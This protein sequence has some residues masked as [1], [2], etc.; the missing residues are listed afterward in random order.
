MQSFNC[1]W[2]TL[3]AL[4]CCIWNWNSP[5]GNNFIQHCCNYLILNRAGRT[6]EQHL[7]SGTAFSPLAGTGSY[8]PAHCVPT[9]LLNSKFRSHPLPLFSIFYL[10]PLSRFRKKKKDKTQYFI[11]GKISQARYHHSHF[12]EYAN[13]ENEY[14][15]KCVLF[16]DVFEGA[17]GDDT[18]SYNFCGI[19]VSPEHAREAK[20]CFQV[21]IFTLARKET[22]REKAWE[23]NL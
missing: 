11:R 18:L 19:S 16:A 13:V 4:I 22:G 8:R 15:N 2:S 10:F 6:T 20:C 7:A 21:M 14:S 5:S 12:I 9:L 3:L 1:G 17:K 23:G